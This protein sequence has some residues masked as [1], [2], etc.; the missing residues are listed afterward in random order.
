MIPAHFTD[1]LMLDICLNGGVCTDIDGGFECECSYPYFG[2]QCLYNHDEC[3]CPPNH[4]CEIEEGAT[5]CFVNEVPRDALIVEGLG[6]LPIV[7]MNQVVNT[8]DEKTSVQS[9][10]IILFLIHSLTYSPAIETGGIP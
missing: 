2:S 4:V 3:I 1:L 10:S 6:S 8:L 5:F 9:K 7:S